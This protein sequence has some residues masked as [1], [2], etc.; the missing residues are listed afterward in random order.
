[1]GGVTVTAGRAGE[2]NRSAVSPAIAGVE[3]SGVTTGYRAA[4]DP[5]AVGL[6]FE[7]LVSVVMEREDAKT[8]NAFEHALVVVPEVR[9]GERLF[10]EPDYLL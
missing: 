9:H 8:I 6:G 10:C 2:A 7:T 4:V 3:R 5:A 1:M